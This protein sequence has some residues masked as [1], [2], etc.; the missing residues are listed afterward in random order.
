MT[1]SLNKLI[2]NAYY[3]SKVRS[4]DFQNVGGDDITIGIDLLNEILSES[5]I[6]TKMIPYYKEYITPAIIGQET[7]FI[8]NLVQPLS[9]TFNLGT[10]R[11]ATNNLTRFE[12]HSTT[13]IDGIIA[14]PFNASFEKT[15]GGCNLYVQ[16]LP[17]DAY[18]FKIWGKFS[19]SQVDSSQLPDDL[20]TTY[21]MFYLRY[22]RYRLSVEICNFFTVSVRPEVWKE[23]AII[24]GLLNNMNPIDLTTKKVNLYNDR[25]TIN[26]AQVNIGKGYTPAGNY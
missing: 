19:L 14:L 4:A 3:L 24:E 20:L 26:W 17:S 10:V 6:N 16:F 9:L 2:T 1:Y 13:R 7:Y 8:P 21:D 25:N 15:T 11:Y 18:P 23:L 5:S 12:Y 22:L